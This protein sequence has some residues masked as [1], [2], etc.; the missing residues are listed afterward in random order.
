VSQPP[1]RVYSYPACGTCRKALQWLAQKDF[2]VQA[3]SLEL[4]DI[5][6]TPPALAEL[7]QALTAVGRKRLFNTSGQSYRALGSAAVAAMNDDQALAALAADGKLIKRP[8]AI[9]AGG[10]VLVGFKPEEWQAALAG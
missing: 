2:S 10:A 5:T 6:R 8:F 1:L 3:G 9:T 4:V 7:R